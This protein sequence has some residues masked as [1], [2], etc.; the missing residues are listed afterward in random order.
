MKLNRPIRGLPRLSAAAAMLRGALMG[1]TSVL[2]KGSPEPF[3]GTSV[4]SLGPPFASLQSV[5]LRH[6]FAALVRKYY[7][8]HLLYSGI[9]KPLDPE[10][11]VYQ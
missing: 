9:L 5:W 10:G 2:E 8:L 6:P 3:F 11:I 7:S 1:P 4:D